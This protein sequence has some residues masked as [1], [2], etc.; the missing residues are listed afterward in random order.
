MSDLAIG[1]MAF[2]RPHYLA[3]TLASL[4]ANDLTNCDVWLFQDGANCHLRGNPKAKQEDLDKCAMLFA[5]SFPDGWVI[6]HDDNIGI[7]QNRLAL[8]EYL[9]DYPAFIQL[10][11][12]VVVAPQFVSLAR[13]LLG[14]FAEDIDVGFIGSGIVK[15][16]RD[17]WQPN[18]I[19]RQVM[20]ISAIFARKE[21]FA[22]VLKLYKEYCWT[23]KDYPY[24][25]HEPYMEKV[26][27][28]IG[29]NLPASSDGALMWATQKTEHYS[30]VMGAPRA[31]SVGVWGVHCRPEIYKRKGMGELVLREYDGELE[32]AWHK[33]DSE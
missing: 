6:R 22:P 12:D 16:S 29:K 11:D 13:H 7:A 18:T 15:N 27:W 2:D 20:A 28:L 26:A 17:W 4:K 1:V 3:E 25:P 24:T 5:D 9:A 19:Y 30:W 31:R 32:T 21:W 14:Q 8:F 23:I 10:E 33:D